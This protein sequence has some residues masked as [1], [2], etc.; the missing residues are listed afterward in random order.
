MSSLRKLTN[1]ELDFVSGG[2][3][4]PTR[5]ERPIGL[6]GNPLVALLEDILRLVEGGEEKKPAPARKLTA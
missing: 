5:P 3:A 6:G 1:A 2:L 4:K